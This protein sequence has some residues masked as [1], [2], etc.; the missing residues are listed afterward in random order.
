MGFSVCRESRR[1]INSRNLLSRSV[2]QDAFK[3]PSKR[4]EFVRTFRRDFEFG[5]FPDEDVLRATLQLHAEISVNNEGGR[6]QHAQTASGLLT[7]N[8]STIASPKA[9]RA[10]VGRNRDRP[11]S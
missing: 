5:F 9:Q 10:L 11:K 4:C 1:K 6:G 7:Q 8:D 3:I 2:L